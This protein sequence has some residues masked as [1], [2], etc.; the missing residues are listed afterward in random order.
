MIDCQIAGALLDRLTQ[1]VPKRLARFVRDRL[2][3]GWSP[4]QIS[5]W[6]KS[7]AEPGLCALT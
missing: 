1:M 3:E 2:A 6:L 7:G 5:G 4:E